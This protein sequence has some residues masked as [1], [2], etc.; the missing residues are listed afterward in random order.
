V[1]Q[2]SDPRT[3]T[4][5]SALA[6]AGGIPTIAAGRKKTRLGRVAT[7]NEFH[8]SMP[9]LVRLVTVLALI[10]GT[11]LAV[12]AALVTF[13]EPVRVPVSVEVPVPG[14]QAPPPAAPAPT[15]E[16]APDAAPTP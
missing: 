4:A 6:R 13:V 8:P 1:G 3:A 2:A 15:E 12:M 11:V 10:A 16:P 9:T 7:G 14:L 5:Q